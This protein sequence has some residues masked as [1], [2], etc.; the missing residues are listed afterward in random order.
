MRRHRRSHCDPTA[1][2]VVETVMFEGLNAAATENLAP[3]EVKAL[4][5]AYG[6]RDG[7]P[8]TPDETARQWGIRDLTYVVEAMILPDIQAS[9][10]WTAELDREPPVVS[11]ALRARLN[12]KAEPEKPLVWCAR[13][14]WQDPEFHAV[15]NKIVTCEECPCSFVLGD[16]RPRKYCTNACRQAAYRRRQLARANPQAPSRRAR[17][18]RHH[19]TG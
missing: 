13:H 5:A 11:A 8:R 7:V 15:F 9:V 18:D 1:G 2:S 4:D 16:F 6:L 10:S 12:R 3:W 17:Q 14:G 19:R